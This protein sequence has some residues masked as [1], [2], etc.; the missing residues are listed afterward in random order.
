MT[1]KPK[2]SQSAD[3]ICCGPWYIYQILPVFMQDGQLHSAHQD[4]RCRPYSRRP[5][6][7]SLMSALPPVSPYSKGTSV[8]FLTFPLLSYSPL[9]HMYFSH[10]FVPSP[11]TT[12]KADNLCIQS[13]TTFQMSTH[14][15]SLTFCLLFR[16]YLSS[17]RQALHAL[18]HVHMT[19]RHPPLLCG[20][21]L[22]GGLVLGG[23]VL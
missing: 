12:P 16:S 22:M 4:H 21:L 15:K 10:T 7:Y 19:L 2:T 17:I 9:V 3:S 20:W 13:P 23:L 14:Q 5:C 1:V 6:R 18:G 8:R 11:G